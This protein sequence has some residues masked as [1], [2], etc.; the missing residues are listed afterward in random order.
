[1]KEIEHKK[2]IYHT[3]LSQMIVTILLCID[4]HIFDEGPCKHTIHFHEHA[5]FRDS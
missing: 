1:M 3:N 5:V 2:N 4:F